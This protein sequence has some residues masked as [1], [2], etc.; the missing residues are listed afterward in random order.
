MNKREKEYVKKRKSYYG[1]AKDYPG[2]LGSNKYVIG[3]SLTVRRNEVIRKIILV[4][5][6]V[7][8]FVTTFVATTVCLEISEKPKNTKTSY[9]IETEYDVFN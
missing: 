1:F 4:V 6:A 3:D 5:L 9:S 7:L 8:L 2:N